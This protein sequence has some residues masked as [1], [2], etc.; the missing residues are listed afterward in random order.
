MPSISTVRRIPILANRE[1]E[2]INL[3]V[4]GFSTKE[5]AQKLFI[6][7]ETVKTHRSRIM[8]KLQVKKGAGIV[9]EAFCQKI[10]SVSM[11]ARVA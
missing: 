3:I 5:I 1:R 11:D 9:R 2:I 7:T 6:G 4:Y 10:N 8:S